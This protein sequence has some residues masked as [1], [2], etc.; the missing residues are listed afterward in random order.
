M[1]NKI[2]LSWFQNI[3][4]PHQCCPKQIH[5][6]NLNNLTLTQGSSTVPCIFVQNYRPL[7]CSSMCHRW[8]N[9]NLLQYLLQPVQITCLS[10]MSTIS[11]IASDI[12]KNKNPVNTWPGSVNTCSLAEHEGATAW[13]TGHE[14][15]KV[16][17][18]GGPWRNWLKSHTIPHLCFSATHKPRDMEWLHKDLT[19]LKNCFSDCPTRLQFPSQAEPTLHRVISKI[20]K[21]TLAISN[22]CWKHHN[23]KQTKM[24]Q[25]RRLLKYI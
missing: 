5:V 7:H 2:V 1:T 21:L 17:N 10:T 13:Q 12:N 25:R 23:Y 11:A 18:G 20:T 3:F 24:T 22:I 9:Y 15:N 6:P 16:W 8:S 14:E 19:G 4:S